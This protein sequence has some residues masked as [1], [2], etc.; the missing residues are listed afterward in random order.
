MKETAFHKIVDQARYK[1]TTSRHLGAG[2]KK[3]TINPSTIE[4]TSVKGKVERFFPHTI[5]KR[6]FW[7]QLGYR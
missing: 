2:R 3:N 7:I 4:T 1:I 5:F 6:S